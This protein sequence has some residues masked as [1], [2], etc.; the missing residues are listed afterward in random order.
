[1]TQRTWFITGINSGFGR[2]MTEQLLE[3][4]DRVA[5]TVRKPDSL[6][7]LVEKYGSNLWVG[8]LD[9]TDT[10]R[11][12][13]VVDQA[14][15]DLGTIDVV[16]NN[17]GYGLFG[18]V[19]E[20]RVD[21]IR[22]IVETNLIGSILLTRAALP[23]LRA[24]GGGRI[25]Q[26]STYGGQATGPGASMYHASKW[27]IE[28]FMESTAKDV[29][30]F[31]IGVTII[32]PGGARTEFRFGSSQLGQPIEAYDNSPAAMVRQ[33]KDRSHP[34]LGDPSKIASIVIGSADQDPAP[35]RIAL[36]SDSFKFIHAA[37]TSRL[38]ELEKQEGLAR[39]TDFST[40]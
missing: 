34:S 4:G 33:V 9:V 25:I 39:S 35:L 40:E 8:I 36:G 21:Q 1:M 19:E 6:D 12:Q 31:N 2:L 16:V 7:D 38:A 22:H 27:G 28:G 24:Q 14:F 15:N 29:A 23:H 30:P 13:Q 18:A 26:I 11:V 10:L 17:A 32:E 37:L 5:G 3:R 20:L